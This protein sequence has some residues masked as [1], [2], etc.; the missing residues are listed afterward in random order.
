MSHLL[1]P[2]SLYGRLSLDLT[3]LHMKQIYFEETDSVSDRV[4][5]F[6]GELLAACWPFSELQS[7][8]SSA[9]SM[10]EQP[11]LLRYRVLLFGKAT[12]QLVL[13]QIEAF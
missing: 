6:F 3:V 9:V 8:P 12:L 4:A 10:T 1:K 13:T 5:L 2:P 11:Y 7:P